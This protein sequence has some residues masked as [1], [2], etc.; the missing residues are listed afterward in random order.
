MDAVFDDCLR[1]A[2][3]FQIF[4][5]TDDFRPNHDNAVV[6][7]KIEEDSAHPVKSPMT[8][9]A[10]SPIQRQHASRIPEDMHLYDF[11]KY[12]ACVLDK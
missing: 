2:F 9:L 7:G 6:S 8:G 5:C 12:M 3:F 10:K 4:I 11:P 1:K